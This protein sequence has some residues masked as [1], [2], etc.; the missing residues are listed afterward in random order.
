MD[1]RRDCL[2]TLNACCTQNRSDPTFLTCPLISPH[3]IMFIIVF[4]Q[5]LEKVMRTEED[6]QLGGMHQPYG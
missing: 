1:C 2:H 5:E 3:L 4:L 6:L